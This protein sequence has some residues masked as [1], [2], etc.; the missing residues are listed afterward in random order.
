MPD[1]PPRQS[2]LILDQGLLK[3]RRGKPIHG[4]ELFRLLLIGQLIDLG[5][6]VTVVFER[7]WRPTVNDRLPM[8]DPKLRVLYTPPLGG[9]LTNALWGAWIASLGPTYD[10]VLY[11]NARRGLIPAM[12]LTARRKTAR[13]GLL[14]A[15]RV[16]HPR[17]LEKTRRVPYDVLAVSEHVAKRFRERTDRRVDVMYGLPN[18][19]LFHP[20]ETPGG[21]GELVHFCLLGRLPNISKGQDKAIAAYEA[22]A[23]ALRERSRL[24]LASFV[25]PT[26]I[27][28]PGVI[29][30]D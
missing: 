21:D 14:F 15:H 3:N 30:H 18:A 2:V 26:T 1:H 19:E 6:A 8:G 27:E 29:A 28:T 4:V 13:R 22:M 9:V 12:W 7:S 20:P 23:P 25:T 17:L 24:H 16:P 5:V 10:V 11:G